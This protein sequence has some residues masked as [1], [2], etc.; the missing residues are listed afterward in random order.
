MSVPV[1]ARSLCDLV[2]CLLC[3]D[4]VCFQQFAE[5]VPCGWREMMCLPGY[6]LFLIFPM[7]VT[8]ECMESWVKCGESTSLHTSKLWAPPRASGLR[9]AYA[10]DQ[11]STFVFVA[12]PD[13]KTLILQ[14]LNFWKPIKMCL[15]W[16]GSRASGCRPL[17]LL[18]G[19]LPSC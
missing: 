2:L 7:S 12:C 6:P 19:P 1:R 16:V 3:P 14:G 5:R 18:G 4:D 15:L 11:A 13:A 9:G 10:G 17:P 8:C